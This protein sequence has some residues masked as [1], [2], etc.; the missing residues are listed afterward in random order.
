MLPAPCQSSGLT[1]PERGRFP[2][3]ELTPG[4]GSACLDPAFHM[5]TASPRWAWP[6]PHWTP[7]H[8]ASVSSALN[9]PRAG[10]NQGSYPPPS[11]QGLVTAANPKMPALSRLAFPGEPCKA[12]ASVSP[13][14]CLFLAG[15][16][17]MSPGSLCGPASQEMQVTNSSSHLMTSH[18]HSA[19]PPPIKH[20]KFTD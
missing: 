19:V 11:P 13:C 20:N 2:Q 1:D 16:P 15:L 7:T 18:R 4:A 10:A 6:P 14:S 8:R 3:S 9:Q 17:Q 5:H 12:P